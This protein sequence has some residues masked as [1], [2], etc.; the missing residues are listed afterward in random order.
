MPVGCAINRE[1]SALAGI[2]NGNFIW[3]VVRQYANTAAIEK[4]SLMT[5]RRTCAR[6]CHSTGDQSKQIQVIKLNG[7]PRRDS[8]PVNA[9]K[10]T[11]QLA[12]ITHC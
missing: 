10:E 1:D 8:N 2:A 5:I 6:L 4:L 3:W 9:V 11:G 12:T 7:R